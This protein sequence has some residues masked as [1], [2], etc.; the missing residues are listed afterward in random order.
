MKI[1]KRKSSTRLLKNYIEILI[2]IIIAI[3]MI[4]LINFTNNKFNEIM[5]VDQEAMLMN[6]NTSED[7]YNDLAKEIVDFRPGACKMIESF[8]EDF[9]LIFRVQFKNNNDDTGYDD[10]KNYP[11]LLKIFSN[12]QEGHTNIIIDDEEEDVYFRWITTSS[13]DP[14]LMV[15]YMAR[16]VIKNLWLFSFTCY[17][18][19]ILIFILIV[20]IKYYN[21]KLLNREYE[22]LQNE[23]KNR[24]NRSWV[25]N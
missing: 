1:Q 23:I 10:L 7:V 21:N 14:E 8:S 4:F 20:I 9:Q 15:I 3:L 11:D 25:Y 17:L 19:L 5:Q 24:I 16:P 13:G 6:V 18:I 22:N 2:L 12:N